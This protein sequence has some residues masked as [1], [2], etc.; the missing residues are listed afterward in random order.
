MNLST[1]LEA[2]LIHSQVAKL[3]VLNKWS[4]VQLKYGGICFFTEK[5]LMY[6]V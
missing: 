1:V 5:M 6:M 4:D 3:R 2:K